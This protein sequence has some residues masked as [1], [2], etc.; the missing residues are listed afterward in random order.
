MAEIGFYIDLLNLC[1]LCL[2]HR[3]K[4]Q[5]KRSSIN[6]LYKN[7]KNF[8]GFVTN[9]TQIIYCMQKDLM[10]ELFSSINLVINCLI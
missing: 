2:R 10:Q 6:P 7:K 8:F 5:T 4:V 3:Q 1:M 9:K